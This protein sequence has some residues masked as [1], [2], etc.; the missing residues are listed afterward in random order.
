MS[1]GALLGE[2]ELYVLAAV[3]RLDGEAYGIA[4]ADEIGRRTGRIASLGSVYATVERLVDKGYLAFRLGDAPPAS[5][6]RARKF[7]RITPAGERAFAAAVRGLD[8]MFDGLP[9]RPASAT[10]RR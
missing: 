2:F 9:V 8:R 1:R 5:G 4:I 6:G 3:Q 7:S 10:L